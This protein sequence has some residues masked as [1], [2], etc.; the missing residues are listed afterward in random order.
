MFTCKMI[1]VFLKVT[2]MRRNWMDGRHFNGEGTA[3]MSVTELQR[4]R[5]VYLH[6]SLL[7]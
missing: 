6:L 1:D 3:G 7:L 5:R 2:F 4:I